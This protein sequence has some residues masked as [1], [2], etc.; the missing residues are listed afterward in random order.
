MMGVGLQKAIN[1]LQ[2]ATKITK[3]DKIDYKLC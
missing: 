3:C 1:E 2:S